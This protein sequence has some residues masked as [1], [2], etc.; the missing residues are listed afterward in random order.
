MPVRLAVSSWNEPNPAFRAN[1]R[2][3]T[4]TITINNL[5]IGESYALL[6]YSSYEHVPIR[7]DEKTFLQSKFKDKHEFTATESNYIYRDPNTISSAE[8][9]YYRCIRKPEGF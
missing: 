6:R 5:T 8:S 1:P 7:G 3:M 2:Q 4:G 9:V